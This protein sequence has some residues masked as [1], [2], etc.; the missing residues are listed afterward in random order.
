DEIHGQGGDDVIDAGNG[1]NRIFGEGGNDHITAGNGNQFILGDAGDD[2]IIVG[3]GASVVRGNG[4]ADTITIAGGNNTVIGD[5]TL[6]LDPEDVTDTDAGDDGADTITTGPG[7]DLIFGYGGDD[8][9]SAG[10]GNDFIVAGAGNDTVR[11]GAGSDTISGNDGDDTLYAGDDEFGTPG[12]A[13]STSSINAGTG[14]DLVY[15]DH[16]ADS[17]IG[18]EGDDQIFARAGN[19]YVEG[20]GG[21]DYVEGGAGDDFIIGGLGDDT[22]R[23]EA[24]DDVVWGGFNRDNNNNLIDRAELLA[25]FVNPPGYDAA[26]ARFPTGYTPPLI[27][28]ALLNGQSLDGVFQDEQ[29]NPN[30]F[31][32]HLF[33]GEGTDWMFGG[34]G[35]D[36]L[37]GGGGSDYLDGGAERDEVFGEG[38]DDIVRG[39][40]NDD[41]VHGDY[42]YAQG[43]A[44]IV[45]DEGIDQVYGD[46]GSD[47]VFGDFAP[48]MAVGVPL[49]DGRVPRGTGQRLYGGDGIDFLYAFAGVTINA[50]DA[51]L[52][53]E[54]TLRGDELH[55]GAGGD[56]LY[57]NL[58]QDVLVG[59]S[60][61]DYLH[62][63]FLAGPQLA[64]NIFANITGGADELYGGTGEDQLLGGGGDDVLWGGG[65]T[66]WLEG[67]KGDDTLYGGGAIDLMVLDTRIEYF[68]EGDPKMPIATPATDTFDGH[69]G[70]EFEGD[71]ADDNA[72]DIMLIEGTGQDDEILIGQLADGRAH[73]NM[74]TVDPDTGGTL[75][76]EILVPWRSPPTAE[77]PLGRPLVEQFRISGLLRDDHI[78]FV[79]DPYTAF[80]RDIDALDIGDL[81]ARSDDFVGVIDGGPGDDVLI[82]T[83]GRDRIDGMSGSDILF[84]LAGDDRLWGDSTSSDESGPS[85]DYDILFGG[86]GNDD[87][88][89]GPGIND[90]YAWTQHPQPS[91][92]PHF[93]VFV[94]PGA[95]DGPVFDSNADLD[96][97]GDDDRVL[98]DTGLD[99]MLGSRN[100]DRL[101]AGTGLAFM[102]GNGGDD[103]MFRKDG[104]LFESLDGGLNGDEWKEFLKESDRVFYVSGTEGDDR[105]T[106]DFVN[107]PGLLSDRHLVTRLTSNGDDTFSF[108]AQ[109]HFDL[110]A[111]DESGNPLFDAADVVIRLEALQ[112]RGT[113][114][115]SSNPD[116]GMSPSGAAT[117]ALGLDSGAALEGLLPQE[118][119]IDVILI[120]ALGGNDEILIGPTV[121]ATVWIDAGPGD[122]RVIISGGHVILS[123]RTEFLGN[124]PDLTPRN[125]VAETAFALS[126]APLAASSRFTGLTIDSPEDV[127]WYRFTLANAPAEGSRVTLNS[128]SDLDGLDIALFNV[129]GTDPETSGLLQIGRDRTDLAAAP[130]NGVETAF[131]LPAVQNIGRVTGLTVHSPGDVDVFRFTL[132]RAGIPGDRVNLVLESVDDQTLIELLDSTGNLIEAGVASAPLVRS[133]SLAGR[134]AGD[135]HVRVKTLGAL[136]RYDLVFQLPAVQLFES[137]ITSTPNDEI[138]GALDLGA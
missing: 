79:A 40:K 36:E 93:G 44:P 115:D 105:I 58:R 16:G 65:D 67:Q 47:F 85:N 53:H 137:S 99:R 95:P 2:V 37:F 91:G 72:T 51:A 96:A 134:A 118:G 38:G 59:D 19:D 73:V 94:N 138:G 77:F 104:S 121:Q 122:D 84:G 3:T 18:D 120:D 64:Q 31:N 116:T 124:N 71:I 63:E 9:I 26:E 109:F 108:S 50:G 86:R 25:A 17:I 100:A 61:N 90:L 52:E 34:G 101:Y 15:G 30:D 23:G 126:A 106:V 29:G 10:G 88:I 7:N 111:T 27:T 6:S 5:G 132:D 21:D 68:F 8:V 125:D 24:G 28:P 119:P 110:N 75:N 70:N 42:K 22:I 20:N 80:G 131:Q 76:W 4:G 92:D 45:G 102:F 54:F 89:G 103:Q 127:D 55:G 114:Q 129:G 66:D 112:Q 62:G 97:D 135:Y 87:L 82:G 123:D 39:G 49:P 74:Q 78:A 136:A 60:G 11:G 81:T 113:Q 33:G 69:F 107:E 133:V 83:A 46:G 48:E 98:E 117:Q 13:G 14:N 56:W 130:A 12:E 43:S 35:R 32:D 41:V 57:G 128:R 1:N